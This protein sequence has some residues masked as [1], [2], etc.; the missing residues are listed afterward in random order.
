MRLDTLDLIA[1]GR[2][3]NQTLTFPRNHEDFHVIYGANEAGKSTTLAAIENFLFGIPTRSPYTFLHDGPA[4]RIGSK[5][6]ASGE[7]AYFVRRKG[8]KGTLLDKD[9]TEL[10]ESMMGRLLADAD[11]DFFTRMFSLNHERLRAG[12]EGI[13]EAKDQLGEILFAAGSGIASLG[14]E[15]RGMESAAKELWTPTRKMTLYR[16]GYD[17]YRDG[18]RHIKQAPGTCTSL[19]SSEGSTK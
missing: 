18:G 2:F 17:A 19:E 10:A 9:G 8:T 12:G 13:L 7:N 1:F 15:L 14:E 3:T 4:M 5:I 6:E 11:E 16:Q